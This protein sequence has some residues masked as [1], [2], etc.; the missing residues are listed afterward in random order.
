MVGTSMRIGTYLMYI[1]G[2]GR[3]YIHLKVC[4]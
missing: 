3:V 2:R 1:L 4:R